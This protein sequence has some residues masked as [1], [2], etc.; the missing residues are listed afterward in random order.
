MLLFE[1]R[2]FAFSLT[3][4]G[5]VF[6]VCSLVT[7]AYINMS[8]IKQCKIIVCIDAVSEI[9]T[10]IDKKS[11][12]YYC[13]IIMKRWEA[14]LDENDDKGWL[15][16]LDFNY[17]YRAGVWFSG[18]DIRFCYNS[19]KTYPY[20][21]L[22]SFTSGRHSVEFGRKFVISGK[23]RFTALGCFFT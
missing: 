9:L 7:A 11:N 13:E 19:E 1:F 2:Q 5:K 20:Q 12:T 10:H 8:V 21:K 3:N 17:N 14:H 4:F 22:S 16:T 6:P 15:I 23:K 18:K